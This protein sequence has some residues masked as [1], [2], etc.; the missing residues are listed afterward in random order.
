MPAS[1]ST[2]TVMP[3]VGMMGVLSSPN[4][5]ARM[6]SWRVTPTKSASGAMI[7]MVSAACPVPLWMKKLITDWITNIFC[8]ENI[9]ELLCT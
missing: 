6:A 4:W 3:E 8:A 5:K 7:G 2:P 9:A 1:A